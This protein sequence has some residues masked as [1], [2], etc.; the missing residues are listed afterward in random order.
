MRGRKSQV[1]RHTCRLANDSSLMRFILDAAAPFHAAHTARTLARRLH[2][3]PRCIAVRPCGWLFTA[4]VGLLLTQ[5]AAG[6]PNKTRG[7]AASTAAKATPTP[8][9][10]QPRAAA[11]TGASSGTS[12][13]TSTVA[14]SDSGWGD[15]YPSIKRDLEAGRPLVVHVTVPLCSNAQ[16]DCGASWAGQPGRLET[17]LYWGAI[18][19]ARRIF[20]GKRS[21]WERVE[22]TKQDDVYLERVVYRRIV[23][24]KNWHLQRCAHPT[25]PGTVSKAPCQIEQ[26]V[27]L[28]AVHG[29]KIDRAIDDLWRNATEGARVSFKDPEREAD[30]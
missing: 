27:V 7:S 24:A 3:F 20:D 25:A 21:G 10:Q 22:V 28:Q 19:G 29:S 6:K 23:S 4:L 16:I 1:P 18:F 15:A 9:R 13:G 2:A 30:A 26:L 5:P 8:A 12:S 17:N 11:S 14:P